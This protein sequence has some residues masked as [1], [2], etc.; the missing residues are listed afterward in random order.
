MQIEFQ[1]WQQ[2]LTSFAY[3]GKGML[4]VFLVIGIII[5]MIMALNKLT[6]P[7]ADKNDTNSK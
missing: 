4:G 1:G 6:A 2:F 7:K 5:L 3:M